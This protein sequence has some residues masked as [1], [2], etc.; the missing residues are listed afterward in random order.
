MMA[1]G[2]GVAALAAHA[3]AGP[4]LGS[5]AMLLLTN[6][7][8]LAVTAIALPLRYVRASIGIAGAALAVAGTILF[9]ADMAHRGFGH[10]AL[11]PDAAPIGG[12]LDIIGWIIVAVAALLAPRRQNP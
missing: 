1:A 9:A 3:G 8:M 7:P 11:F 2:I 12:S 10:G 4:E 5:A 6:P